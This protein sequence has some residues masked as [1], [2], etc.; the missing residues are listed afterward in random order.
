MQKLEDEPEIEFKNMSRSYDG[1]RENDFNAAYFEAWCS[2]QTGFP[3]VDASMRALH[4][5][6]WIYFRMLAML[7]SFASYDLWLHWR[8][9]AVYLAKHFLDFEPG[10]RFSQFQIQSGTTGIN[11]LR[12]FSP[13]KQVKD[14]DPEG[15]FIKRRPR[16]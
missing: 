13:A 4:Q 8:P 16:P 11:T 9:P 1:V 15:K 12:I 7:V 2:G 6:G 3:M 10:I 14:H 5:G